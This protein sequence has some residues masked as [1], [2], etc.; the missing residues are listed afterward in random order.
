MSGGEEKYR[1]KS[2]HSN[3]N[4]GSTQYNCG[5]LELTP[6]GILGSIVS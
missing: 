4:K 6:E 3:Y 2:E 5:G 1:Q